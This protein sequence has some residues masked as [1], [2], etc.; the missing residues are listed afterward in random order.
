LAP[1]SIKRPYEI[2]EAIAEDGPIPTVDPAACYDARSGELLMNCYDTL[3]SY[4]GERV[5]RYLPQLATEWLIK[6]NNPPIHDNATGLNWYYTYYFR[7]RQDV[8]FQNPAFGSLTPE[9]VEYCFERG[10]ILDP[11]DGPQWM[12]YEPLLN[13]ETHTFVN[14][15]T[16][17]PE[18]N[19][20]QRELLGLMID[21]VVESNSTHVWF[22]LAFPGA[23]SPLLQI[24]CQPCSSIFSK[25]WANSLGRSTNWP[26]DWSD[27]LSWF[28]YCDPS[29][30]PLDDP[31][32]AV[33]G[34]GPFK[35]AHLDNAL[36]YWDADR[37]TD[38]WRG[39]PLDWPT[40]GA[41]RP[42]GY[43]DHFKVIWG[44]DWATLKT[45]FLN[46]D[47]DFCAVPEDN[48]SEVEGQSGIRCVRPLPALQAW[49]L[50]YNF[51]ISPLSPWSP[52]FDRG[53]LGETGVP[54][55]FFGNA[56]W[57][58]HVRRGF[59]ASID[60]SGFIQQIYH[61]EAAQPA[62]AI[63]PGL[64][65][66][67][68]AVTGYTFNLTRAEEEFKKVPGLWDTGFTITLPYYETNT[69]S[70]ILFNMMKQAIESLNPRFH[71]KIAVRILCFDHARPQDVPASLLAWLADY[72]D[73]HNFAY[74]FYHTR[75]LFAGRASYSNPE[76]DL[77]IER[78]IATPD[79]PERA[80]VYHDIQQLMIE[81]CPSVVLSQPTARH[82]ERDW[83]CGW[84]YNPIYCDWSYQGICAA[85]VWKCYYAPHAFLGNSTQPTLG[86]L[87][88][89]VNHDG[90][91]DVCDLVIV[92]ASFG[93]R[94]GPPVQER[95]S[96]RCDLNE[97]REINMLDLLF[98]A[99]H[100]GETSAVW[101]PPT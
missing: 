49:A 53:V 10:M 59:S 71:L 33:M 75:G 21:H 101:T 77:L 2:I 18:G 97:D 88:C 43:V 89:D 72:P 63:V 79:S 73:A 93:A 38:Y 3:V 64:H 46:G 80:Q 70:P 51:D 56:S 58:L 26:G 83:V 78:G 48:M 98:A 45:A 55:D 44:Y 52:I 22:H 54:R 99:K 1:P 30:P 92:A 82:F 76:A 36:Q 29:V 81:D 28:T 17:D 34:T 96:F 69:V 27:H 100:F 37:F 14:G 24:L 9:D 66:Y 61:G 62:T 19:M 11:A 84:Y 94:Y 39:W 6:Q 35:L 32:P 13:G 41:C 15:Q 65:Y 12:L 16:W 95:W 85:N 23:Y 31:T 5:N 42:A 57:G 40:Y 47:V 7:I 8:P 91:V 60:F 87:P 90:K 67:D 86:H 50:S 68:P 4:D 74:A 20:A 25:A